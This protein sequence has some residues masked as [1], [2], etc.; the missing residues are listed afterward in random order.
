[1][2]WRHAGAASLVAGRPRRLTARL[3]PL[4]QEP[5]FRRVR[6]TIVSAAS[7]GAARQPYPPRRRPMRPPVA[8]A[9]RTAM[10][11]NRSVSASVE[12]GS[13]T[14]RLP[15]QR[16]ARPDPRPRSC[17]HARPARRSS[18]RPAPCHRARCA[19]PGDDGPMRAGSRNQTSPLPILVFA[20]LGRGK[21]RSAL[22]V[23]AIRRNQGRLG[24]VSCRIMALKSPMP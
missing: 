18:A 16:L 24:G 17:S 22:S 10:P 3:R 5:R 11:P 19:G 9:H 21:C 15:V 23:K 7:V 12:G 14:R 6:T 8:R 13:P 2:S 20:P 1:M 4:N